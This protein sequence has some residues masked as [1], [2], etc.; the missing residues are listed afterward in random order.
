MWKEGPACRKIGIY[1]SLKMT[2]DAEVSEA[3]EAALASEDAAGN[4]K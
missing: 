3:R 4:R 2:S 1:A